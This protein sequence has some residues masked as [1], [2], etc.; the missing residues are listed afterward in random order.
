MPEADLPLPSDASSKCRACGTTMERGRV[1]P[2][3]R[4]LTSATI[5]WESAATGELTELAPLPFFG[6][7][8]RPTFP[9]FRCA[10]CRRVEFV[11]PN[12][13]SR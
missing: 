2:G 9:A 13:S 7:D 8:D 3:T 4:N 5:S 11:Y 6:F 10:T 1:Q 12:P